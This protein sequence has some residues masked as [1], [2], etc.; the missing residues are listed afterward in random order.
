VNGRVIKNKIDQKKALEGTGYYRFDCECCKE[1]YLGQ[2]GRS[3]STGFKEHI[4]H[5]K[6]SGKSSDY[7]TPIILRLGKYFTKE[8]NGS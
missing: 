6:N 5:I 1:L 3:F 8:V 7:S 2:T 4:T